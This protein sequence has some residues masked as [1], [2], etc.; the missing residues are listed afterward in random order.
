MGRERPEQYEAEYEMLVS[1]CFETINK[2]L[3]IFFSCTTLAIVMFYFPPC[4]AAPHIM[5]LFIQMLF[6][7]CQMGINSALHVQ[8]D[9]AAS[10]QKGHN[11]TLASEKL[12][13]FPTNC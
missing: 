8:Q 2:S 10:K 13:H 11:Q 5:T 7:P 12:P 9:R 3:P 1:V 6:R 4:F